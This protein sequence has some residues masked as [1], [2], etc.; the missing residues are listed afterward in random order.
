MK[1]M[2]VHAL[3]KMDGDGWMPLLDSLEVGK[4]CYSLHVSPKLPFWN[5]QLQIN[6]LGYLIGMYGPDPSLLFLSVK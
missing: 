6:M 4:E 5:G 1:R 2:M 3:L